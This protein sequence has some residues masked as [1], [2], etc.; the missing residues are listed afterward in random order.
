M[1]G[2]KLCGF[3]RAMVRKHT[4]KKRD[5]I[6]AKP[7]RST[8]RITIHTAG[9]TQ[10]GLAGVGEGE[11]RLTYPE[12]WTVQDCLNASD[13]NWIRF[14]TEEERQAIQ[15]DDPSQWWQ[16]LEQDM[17]PR[18]FLYCN[19]TVAEPPQPLGLHGDELQAVPKK[20][21]IARQLGRESLHFSGRH[22]G[23]LDSTMTGCVH[24]IAG[25][26]VCFDSKGLC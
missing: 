3:K 26:T 22:R 17:V 11:E 8:R 6:F 7:P 5:Y 12:H 20:G 13:A 2:F 18:S 25:R 19:S 4:L 23:P 10:I 15:V 9:G 21:D 1:L 14:P 16:R 24:D